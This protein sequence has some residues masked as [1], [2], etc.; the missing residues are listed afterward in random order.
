M[1]YILFLALRPEKHGLQA[2][3]HLYAGQR[4]MYRAIGTKWMHIWFKEMVT[5][6]STRGNFSQT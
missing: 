1:R 3:A 5:Q 2:L 4:A 6:T